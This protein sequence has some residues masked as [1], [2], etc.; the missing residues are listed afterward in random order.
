MLRRAVASVFSRTMHRWIRAGL[1]L[2]VLLACAAG[3]DFLRGTRPTPTPAPTPLAVS[4]GGL[5]VSAVPLYR[6]VANPLLLDAPSRLL[7]L[8][9]RVGT[10]LDRPLSVTP[11]DVALVLANGQRGRVFD[12]GRAMELIRRTM[13]AE[14]DL[15]YLQRHEGY[16]SGGLD[17][18]ARA[19]LSE[20]IVTNL[21]SEGAF[22]NE[23]PAQGYVVIDTS[24]PLASL[25]GTA[26]EVVA[27]RLSDSAPAQGTYQ[28]T[29]APVEADIAPTA[30]APATTD[31]H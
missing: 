13:L 19:G 29:A 11:D 5:V 24:V 21:L 27:Y 16:V 4:L 12:R 3:C 30:A 18:S 28:F 20:M 31:S 8:Q 6:L 23:Y 10:V 7:V 26:L 25:Q 15:A 17:E 1:P 22:T 9:L 2:G 14:A